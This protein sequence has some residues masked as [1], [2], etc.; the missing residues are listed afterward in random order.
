VAAQGG[1]LELRTVRLESGAKVA[2]G[3]LA[4]TM[5]I[6][7]GTALESSAFR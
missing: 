4:A 5:R 1:R 6:T 2:A 7:V 3:A